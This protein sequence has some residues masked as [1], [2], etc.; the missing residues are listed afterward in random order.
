MY[1]ILVQRHYKKNIKL[2]LLCFL[3]SLEQVYRNLKFK[4]VY[5]HILK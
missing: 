1:T 2:V 4:N 5:H 3:S